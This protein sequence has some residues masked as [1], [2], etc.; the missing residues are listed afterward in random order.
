MKNIH[1]LPTS[2]PSNLLLCIKSYIEHKDTPAEN[3]DNKGN[4]RLGFGIYANTEFYQHQNIYITSDEEIKEGD[5]CLDIK[6]NIIFQSKRTEIGTSKK[7]PIIICT[8]EGCYIKEDCKKIILTTDQGLINDGVQAIDDEFLE[9]FVKNPSCESVEVADIW[10]MGIP[11]THDSYQLIIPEEEPRI[12]TVEAFNKAKISYKEP[13][14]D[15]IMERI[16]ANAKQQETTLEEKLDKI[17]SKEPSKFFAE[18]DGRSKLHEAATHYLTKKHLS[19]DLIADK[20]WYEAWLGFRN[21]AKW[22][23]ER[24]YSEEEVLELLTKAH[25]VEQNIVEWFEQFKKK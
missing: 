15:E 18:S 4:F 11:S 14:Q 8:Y 3:S 16:I 6:R 10:K 1:V 2:Q 19:K 7:I 13:K 12:L 22:Q 25:F 5:W 21:G 20:A 23:A 17:V 24:S 9:W